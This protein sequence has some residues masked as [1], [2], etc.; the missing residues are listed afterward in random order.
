VCVCVCVCVYIFNSYITLLSVLNIGHEIGYSV[1]GK[2]K[3]A[4]SLSHNRVYENAQLIL[5][6]HLK[7]SLIIVL[8]FSTY[9]Y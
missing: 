4:D 3:P 8:E 1:L 2:Y 7:V 5:N 6:T 9:D